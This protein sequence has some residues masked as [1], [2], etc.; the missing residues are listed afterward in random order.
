MPFLVAF[1]HDVGQR[2]DNL[3][4][5]DRPDCSKSMVRE[6]PPRRDLRLECRSLNRW[7][8]PLSHPSLSLLLSFSLQGLEDDVK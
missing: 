8:M 2:K 7:L 1:S 5:R 6:Q 4:V 3:Q